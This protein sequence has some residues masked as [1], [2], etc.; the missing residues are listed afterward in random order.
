M[1]EF[2]NIHSDVKVQGA[3]ILDKDFVDYP[4]NPFIGQVIRRGTGLEAYLN[5]G[6]METWYPFANKTRYHVHSQ[7]QASASWVITHN[8]GTSDVWFQVKNALGQ[9]MYVGKTDINE[10]SFR[11]NLTEAM[12]GTVVVVA[13]DSIDV[14][15]I[16]ASSLDVASG[17]VTIDNS[18]I[19]INGTYVLT[20]ASFDGL[21]QATD[22]Q[23]HIDD[24]LNPH[25]VTK[26]QVGLGSV[27]NTSDAE[28]PVSTAT[29]AALDLKADKTQLFSGAYGDLSGLPVIPSVPTVVSA[30][31]NDA[32]YL[33]ASDIAGKANSASLSA[34]ATSGSYLD[35][36]DK[37][38]IPTSVSSFTNDSGF[39]TAAQVDSAI[40]SVVGAAPAA[41][42]TLEEI[43]AQ[44]AL[45]ESAV[46]ALTNVV[47]SKAATTYVDAQLA[48]KVSSSSLATVATSGSYADLSNKPTIPTVPTLV[49]AFTN[50]S[51]YLVSADIG[52]KV[53]KV[54]GKGLST[55]DYSTAEK[56]KLAGIEA[57]A[58]VNTV[59]S[60]AGKTG[61]VTLTK[62]D[63]GLAN[64]DNTSDLSKPISTATQTAL[65]LKANTAN[66][67]TVA[68]TGSYADLSGKP[69]IPSKVSDL[70]N[71]S[72]FQT[73]AQVT[74]A[75][76]AV[77]GA[78]PAALDTLVEIAAQL[79]TDES[80]VAALTTTVSGKV[81]ANAAITAGTGT[82]VTYDAKGLVTGSTTLSASDIPALAWSKITSGVPTTISGYG[83]T[84]AQPL[85]ADL[86]SIAGLA[87][88]SGLLKKTAAN[89]WSLDTNTYLT[90][91]QSIT[92]SG[93]ATGTGSTAIALTLASITD[94]G[95]G[96]FKKL[97]VNGK[98]L[99]TGTASVAQSDITGLLGAGSITNT[100]LANSAVANLSGTNTGDE[101]AATIKTKLGITTLSGPNTGDQTITLTGDATGTG[102]GSFAVTLANS[103]A[104]AGTY[105]SVTVDAKG[106]VTAGTNPTTLSGY[107]ITDAVSSSLL[108]ANSGVATLDSAGK[109]PSAQLPSY[110]DDV[111][112]YTN[113]AGFPVSGT[114]GVIYVVQDTNKIYRWSGSAY[115]EISPTAGNADTATKL[116]TARSIAMTG[117]VTWSIPS[118]DGSANVTAA[119]TLSNSGVTAGTYKSVAVDA[120][121]RVTAGTNPTTLSGYGITDAQPLDLDLISIA[122][123]VG[124][125]GILRKYAANT[126]DLDTSTYLTG[127]Q[128]I[129][130]TGDVS[131]SG[132]TSLTLTLSNSGV[133]AGTYGSATQIVPLVIDAKGR[134]TSTGTAVTIAP[135]FSSIT[136]KPT[137]FT[138][139][140]ISDTL[141]NLN[142]AISDA[143][144][145][146]LAGIETLTNKT[147]TGL[148][149]T[150]VAMAAND[151]ALASGNYFSKTISGATTLTVS[152]TAATGSVS[153][154]ILDLT[155]GG[156]AVVSWF[157]GVKWASGT[158]PTLTSAGRDVLGFFTHDGGTT[159]NGLVL[160]KDIK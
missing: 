131:G 53:D 74:T 3:L 135:A 27:N 17:A 140:A 136:G 78:A 106:R 31:T 98:G 144:V 45:D 130:V 129:S 152:G 42:N 148:K 137:T 133:T 84:D 20:Q 117:D 89:T 145:A 138:G 60:V 88:T 126:W 107:G 109:V 58:Q 149:E 56:T 52:N 66:L 111:L 127:N 104:T 160:A 83:I 85:D 36:S 143:D 13:P 69:T 44:L 37:P 41:L 46:S 103:G 28:K 55:E 35:L 128:S 7:G 26:A 79:A 51:G 154:F 30:F 16:K 101:T 102:T 39:Q 93:D 22:L 72:G 112:E 147:I 10:N 99:V 63:V 96:S 122:A 48:L 110:V 5:L 91:N 71:D 9:V 81:T 92:V 97:T 6:G 57:G 124:T 142:T 119:G 40:Q 59:T 29:Q 156:S 114:A 155:N 90:G 134:V 158:A 151:I 47:S 77:V 94:S 141:A 68:T 2:I 132:T 32:G 38:A 65:N 49:S 70:T 146:S 100:M 43:T 8:L 21:A 125:T 73:S 18:G 150:K 76:Q 113:L 15:T 24:I 1:S 116:A 82:K 50:D 62:A 86:T 12:T 33:V 54:T 120:K 105:K 123:L 95:V 139:Y 14:P 159:W 67:S 80:A 157:S 121:G 4:A 64:V 75:I 34:V 19:K 115:I 108:G 153:S 118:F 87:G 23:A 25:N 61:V 11:L